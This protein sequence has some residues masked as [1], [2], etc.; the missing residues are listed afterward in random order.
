MLKS[1]FFHPAVVTTLWSQSILGARQPARRDFALG[2]LALED[3][4]VSLEPSETAL[5]PFYNLLE[6]APRFDRSG[7]TAPDR[8]VLIVPPMSGAFPFIAR[9]M[10]ARL[11]R[12]ARVFVIEW[13]NARMI[14]GAAGAFDLDDQIDAIETA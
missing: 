12:D 6:F 4:I 1:L 11:A 8:A 5:S 2:D 14:P 13:L 3:G 7:E 10:V 9:D